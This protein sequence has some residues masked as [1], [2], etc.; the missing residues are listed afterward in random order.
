MTEHAT[1]PTADT[2]ATPSEECPETFDRNDRGDTLRI[3]EAL[4]DAADGHLHLIY[5]N[6]IGFLRYEEGAWDEVTDHQV[7]AIVSEVMESFK[8]AALR[9]VDSLRFKAADPAAP[10]ITRSGLRAQLTE[11]EKRVDYYM[12]RQRQSVHETL[13]RSLK[14]QNRLQRHVTELDNRPHLLVVANGTIDLHTG[15]LVANDPANLIT[16]RIDV[17][18]A[19]ER[20]EEGDLL[21]SC[22]RWERFLIE[23]H[24]DPEVVSFLQRVVGYSITGDTS[25]H[26]FLMHTGRGSNGKGTFTNTLTAIFEGIT[27]VRSAEMLDPKRGGGQEMA[28]LR[29][30]RLVVVNE[31]EVGQAISEARL[32]TL[33]GG[34]FITA[35][36]LYQSSMQFK[37]LF[38]MHFS[39]N[40]KPQFRDATDGL[41]RRLRLVEWKRRFTADEMDRTLERQLLDERE[42][43]LVWAVAGAVQWYELG[44]AAPEAVLLATTEYRDVVDPLSGF[45]TGEVFTPEEGGRI[46]HKE[47]HAAY[48]DWLGEGRPWS[49]GALRQALEERGAVFVKGH[50]R[51]F[52]KG[53]RK[54]TSQE[55]RSGLTLVDHS[56]GTTG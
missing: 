42:G 29:G 35:R 51:W 1:V 54:V 18:Y 20:N 41:W 26:C 44:L 48:V 7:A 23:C 39:T 21:P 53:Y 27:T 36:K 30:A 47:V 50:G 6:G 22:P 28:E 24:D 16:S 12:R 13:V 31:G 9:E 49:S 2:D 19:P 4:Y 15:E 55:A 25:E 10:E 38:T 40:H 32:K 46:S 45:L 11:A 43:I 52:M 17:A 33:T 3:I 37:P 5:V 14:G 56:N 8:V 34:D